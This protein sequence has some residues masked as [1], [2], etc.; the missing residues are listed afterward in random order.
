MI[1]WRTWRPPRGTRMHWRSPR[2]PAGPP[3]PLRRHQGSGGGFAEQEGQ[4]RKIRFGAAWSGAN[5][6]RHLTLAEDVGKHLAQRRERVQVNL[7]RLEPLHG[8]AEQIGLAAAS[9]R[10][11]RRTDR[12]PSDR[13]A[14]VRAVR[15]CARGGDDAAFASGGSRDCRGQNSR[16]RTTPASAFRPSRQTGWT[17]RGVRCR[18]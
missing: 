12:A 1:R 10:C 4:R 3:I 14:A 5:R 17:R 16:R 9:S 2:L 6:L 7:L 13:P 11:S 18:K 15:W 8:G